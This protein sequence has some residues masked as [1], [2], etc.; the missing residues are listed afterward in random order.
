ML[1]ASILL[2]KLIFLELIVYFSIC[3]S[4]PVHLYLCC[5]F[6]IIS[7]TEDRMFVQ[8]RFHS[9]IYCSVLFMFLIM[10]FVWWWW[11]EFCCFCHFFPLSWEHSS[12]CTLWWFEIQKSYVYC[13]IA[14]LALLFATS[15]PA[16]LSFLWDKVHF[17]S[18]LSDVHKVLWMSVLPHIKTTAYSAYI[19]MCLS[20]I[21]VLK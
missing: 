3:S 2:W 16:F 8:M 1:K 14:S 6:W 19:F 13:W 5:V 17:H 7:H 11:H 18:I 15:N 9:V 4:L 21:A 12:M 20:Y 10:K